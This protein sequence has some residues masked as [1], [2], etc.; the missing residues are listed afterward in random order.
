MSLI[1]ECLPI[2]IFPMGVT[3]YSV[4]PTKPD[5][6]D[7]SITLI[8]TGGTAPYT[9]I[10][11]N[12]N[13][14]QTINNLSVGTYSATV[15]DYYGDYTAY[16]SCV[17]SYDTPKIT[18]TPT[19]T[20]TP[21]VSYNFCM[22]INYLDENDD[23]QVAQI[24]FNQNGYANWVSDDTTYSISWNN[25]TNQWELTPSL[26]NFTIASTNSNNPPLNGWEVYG[27][28]G[29]VSVVNGSCT[30]V[31]TTNLTYTINQPTCTCD[32]AITL[33]YN[34]GTPPYQYSIDGGATYQNL[35]TFQGLCGDIT[36]G[37]V[38]KDS[39]GFEVTD[40]I[41]LNPLSGGITYTLSMTNVIVTN[42]F[43]STQSN[44]TLTKTFNVSPPLPPGV[45]V[46]FNLFET[47]NFVTAPNN[48]DYINSSTN[49][50]T[51]NVSVVTP[52]N[53]VPV[54]FTTPNDAT[55]PGT[56]YTTTT[57]TYWYNVVLSQG[58][59]LTLV[60]NQIYNRVGF[61]T[62]CGNASIQDKANIYLSSISGCACCNLVVSTPQL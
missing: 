31:P 59:T 62:S 56:Q 5:N 19:P 27:G 22:T 34:G 25:T 55:C 3:C 1:N 26:G 45:S 13:S 20:P 38:V 41:T 18:P 49:T 24:H 4:S 53:I 57:K 12:G 30:S 42:S 32:G 39:L 51:K 36:L 11:S 17:V 2:T 8:V 33:S 54:T 61:T 9:F 37:L 44:R 10:W 35:P 7:G 21:I 29:S 16:T 6:S 52:D 46:T 50:L 48:T 58:D 15:I 60:T 43:S 14:T 40:N 47:N 23:N 28:T